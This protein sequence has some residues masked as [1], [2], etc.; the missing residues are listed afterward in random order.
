MILNALQ[1]LSILFISGCKSYHLLRSLKMLNRVAVLSIHKKLYK[2]IVIILSSLLQLF[3]SEIFITMLY[4][5]KQMK[6]Y[7]L[8]SQYVLHSITNTQ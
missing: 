5:C 3:I 6:D 8:L 4:K 1:K 7:T 2:D